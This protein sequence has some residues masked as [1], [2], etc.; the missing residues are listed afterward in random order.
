MSNHRI[1]RLPSDWLVLAIVLNRAVGSVEVNGNKQVDS[2]FAAYDNPMQ[3]VVLRIREI[4][5]LKIDCVKE[6]NRERSRTDCLAKQ[7]WPGHLLG[8]LRLRMNRAA[9]CRA[10]ES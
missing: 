7:L 2:W 4:R 9:I 3:D 8:D 1:V 6:A 5:V 10:S